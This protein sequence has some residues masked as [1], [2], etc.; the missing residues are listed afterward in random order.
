MPA[1]VCFNFG[2]NRRFL[3]NPAEPVGGALNL[4]EG[5]AAA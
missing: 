1:A 5:A 2:Q 4:Q 3:L